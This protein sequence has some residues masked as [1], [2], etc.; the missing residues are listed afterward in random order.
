MRPPLP[1]LACTASLIALMPV[2]AQTAPHA[3]AGVPV[4]SQAK[5]NAPVSGHLDCAFER[6][7]LGGRHYIEAVQAGLHPDPRARMPQWVAP[8]RSIQGLTEGS[9]QALGVAPIVTSD[10]LFL[11]EDTNSLLLSNFSDADLFDLMTDAANDLMVAHGDNFDF[12]GF[13]LD[14]QADHEIGAAFYQLIENDVTGIGDFSP[15]TGGGDTFN[16][17]PDFGLAGDNVEGYIMMWDLNHTYWAEGTGSDADFT[18]LA[19]GQE[20]EHRFAMF[21]DPLLDGR[22]LQGDNNTCGRGFHWNWQIDGQGSGMEIADWIGSN[23]ALPASLFV[24]FNTDLPGSVFSY[25][26]LYLMG[27]VSPAEMDTGNSELRFMESSD[28]SNNFSGTVSSFDSADIIASNGPRVPDW[29]SAQQDFHT[30]WVVIHLPGQPPS[31]VEMDKVVGILNQH[32]TDWNTSTLGRGTMDN[33]LP[34]TVIQFADLGGG[35]TGINGAPTLTASSALTAGAVIDVDLVNA[36]PSA[37]ML[38]WLSVTSVPL[39]VL[40]GTIFA[41]PFVIKFVFASDPAGEFSLSALW[42]GSPPGVPLYL[43]FLIQDISVPPHITLSNA[44]M[45]ITP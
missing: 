3:Q 4:H 38:A 24:S 15:F 42:P 44:V 27:Y 37:I 43:Q 1:L 19:M 8:R 22:V 20:F 41:N 11:Y 34:D 9:T 25:S 17:R 32:S 36:A 45:A 2:Q 30:G 16:F 6:A 29:N 33:S 10:D 35:T 40:G 18:R 28:C 14:F 13:F 39:N 12:V 5:V 23:P 31:Q 7:S 21:L 26:D